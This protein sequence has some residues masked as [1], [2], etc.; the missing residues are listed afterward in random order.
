MKRENPWCQVWWLIRASIG[1]TLLE[2]A[3]DVTPEPIRRELA[4]ALLP[5]FRLQVSRVDSGELR[6]ISR[7]AR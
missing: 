4:A 2:W 1:E 5:Y 6:R 7:E 3:L